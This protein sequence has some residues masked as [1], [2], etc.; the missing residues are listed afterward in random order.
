MLKNYFKTALRSIL[1]QKAF[2]TINILGLTL[3]LFVFIIIALYVYDDLTFDKYHTN[4]HRLYRLV[5]N[6]NTK[7]W[8]SAVTS[9]PLLLAVGEEVPEVAA[10]TRVSSFNVRYRRE[11]SENDEEDL[12]VVRR[13]VVTGP[14]FFK[15]FDFKIIEGEKDEPLVNPKGV[16]ISRELADA[17]YHDDDPLGQPILITFLQDAYVAGIVETP[18]LN[19]SLQFHAVIPMDV[20][21][22]PDWWD[23][24]ENLAL[25]GF[26]LLHEGAN[27]DA[28]EKNIIHT[29]RAHGMSEVFT[30][31]LQPL[32]DMHLNSVDL[33]YDSY[34]LNK[35][36]WTLVSGLGA[37]GVLVLVIAAFN[38]INLS[39]A[40]SSRRAREV[41]MRK[42]MGSTKGQLMI[43]FLGES[44]LITLISILLAVVAA[45]LLLP[46]LAPFLGKQISVDLMSQPAGLLILLCLGILI[47]GLSGVYPALILAGFKP[48]R[49]LKGSERF[50]RHGMI[51]RRVLVVA[52]FA[53]TIALISGV[54]TVLSQ[55]RFMQNYDF[56]YDRDNVVILPVFDPAVDMN[57]DVSA[58]RFS[59]LPFVLNTGRINLLPG[60]TLPTTEV[61]FDHVSDH[62][63]MFE[64]ITI[65][66]GLTETLNISIIEGRNFNENIISDTAAVLLNRTAWELSGWDNLIHKRVLIRGV[67][68]VEIPYHVVGVV[69]N[70]HFGM[71]QRSVE[72]MVIRLAPEQ[73][74]FMAIRI[75][76]QDYEQEMAQLE[77]IYTQLF[78]DDNFRPQF[79]ED[80]FSA[81]FGSE[82]NFAAKVA[83]FSGLAIVI[84]CLGLTGLASFTVQDRRREIAVRKVVGANEL[85]IVNLLSGDFLKWVLTANILGWPLAWIGS[86]IWLENF[87][88][89]TSIQP[90]LFALSGLI[91]LVIAVLSVSAQTLHAALINPVD[92]LRNE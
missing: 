3:G 43:Q 50:G 70:I 84:A 82:R 15:T 31:V 39:S 90:A 26:V 13:A 49:V 51:L 64:E 91:V 60:R 61:Y 83:V 33:R 35:S 24:W 88:Y 54:L 53:I 40:R 46:V 75:L 65:D 18:P 67:E 87:V 27:P 57:T 21:L 58:D 42:V 72:P 62:G 17:L 56:G 28:A 55:I 69:E 16:Y 74:G 85:K 63:T 86:R 12:S 41:G 22:N 73:A 66:G 37:I 80:I 23:S 19:S 4:A 5:S 8:I 45:E 77:E 7:N 36:S 29:A 92:A 6:D 38:F 2:S 68:A 11:G 10:S 20:N 44:I 47:G 48:T 25:S 14:G 81:Q 78:P 71:A 89:R 9:G 76:N 34:N 52:Q 59:N 79:F 32:L 1:R 30:P